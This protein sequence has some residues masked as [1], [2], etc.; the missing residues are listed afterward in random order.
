[1]KIIKL[2]CSSC[3]AALEVEEDMEI[4]LCEYCGS[5]VL[6]DRGAEYYNHELEKIKIDQKHEINKR[7][8][9]YE[10]IRKMKEMNQNKRSNFNTNSSRLNPVNLMLIISL[11]MIV[12][13][14]I[15]MSLS[16]NKVKNTCNEIEECIQVGNYD[17]ARRLLRQLELDE[18]Q[19]NEEIVAEYS[20]LIENALRENNPDMIREI[21]IPRDSSEFTKLTVEEVQELLSNLGFINIEIAETNEDLF[22]AFFGVRVES[23]SI[24]GEYDFSE[25]DEFPD[26]AEVIIIPE[27]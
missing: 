25:G 6:I 7:K 26:N 2:K 15:L 23:V 21:E 13:P 19:D 10:H 3:G 8:A 24:N 16:E 11:C 1:M 14:A 27:P 18:F 9:Q 5:K 17:E 12:L 20:I 4:C 22:E